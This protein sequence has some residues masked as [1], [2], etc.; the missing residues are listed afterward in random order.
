MGVEVSCGGVSTWGVHMG[1]GVSCREVSG[2]LTWGR[3]GAVG[4]EYLG[5]SIDAGV[6]LP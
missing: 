3:K 2:G 1:A 6:E 4:D 5:G